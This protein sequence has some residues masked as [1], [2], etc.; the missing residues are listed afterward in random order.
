VG[1]KCS[2]F[3]LSAWPWIKPLNDKSSKY[4]LAKKNDAFYDPALCK[5][6]LHWS[7]LWVDYQKFSMNELLLMLIYS[8]EVNCCRNQQH[9]INQLT[10]S[11]FWKSKSVPYRNDV[12]ALKDNLGGIS[13]IWSEIFAQFRFWTF[14]LWMLYFQEWPNALILLLRGSDYVIAYSWKI[15]WLREGRRWAFLGM[16]KRGGD[17]NCSAIINDGIRGNAWSSMWCL[18]T[19]YILSL[20]L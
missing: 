10:I 14:N 1:K 12:S 20:E 17:S 5:N 18:W 19:I 16:A 9:L 4:E 13:S 3:F 8:S 7:S 15:H 6:K 2:D 11:S